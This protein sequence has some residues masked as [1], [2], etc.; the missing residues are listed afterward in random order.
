MPVI[1]PKGAGDKKQ[2]KRKLT[3][4]RPSRSVRKRYT[5]LL[6][7]EVDLLKAQTANLSDMIRSDASRSAVAQRLEQMSMQN[8][9]R[10]RVQAPRIAQ[11]FV[12]DADRT[13]KKQMENNISRALGVDSAKILDAPKTAADVALAID[14]NT[15][16]IKSIPAQH[17]DRVG[18]AVLNNY[19]GVE[20]PEGLSLTARL[21]RIGGVTENRARFIAR[22]QTAKLTSALNRSRQEGVGIDEYTW[23]NSG[24]ARVVGNPSGKYPDPTDG[25][26]DHWAREGKTFR[27]DNPPKDGAPG[28][29]FNC[30]CVALP[31]L[32]L[33][34]IDAMFP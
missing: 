2:R 17:L 12:D 23:Q 21:M 29:S 31:V 32:D 4:I 34:K 19:R 22:D 3:P 20:D 6:V 8:I 5:D 9:E 1:L 27:W 15:S 28:E 7:R 14:W 26:G 25:H 18:Q 11:S 30:R 10:M 24:D 16:L 33:D 13:Q